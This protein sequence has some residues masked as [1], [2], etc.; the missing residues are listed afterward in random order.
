MKAHWQ[1]IYPSRNET[2]VP[3]SSP[4]LDGSSRRETHKQ[5]ASMDV[6]VKQSERMGKRRV[7]GKCIEKLA[8]TGQL[9][10]KNAQNGTAG[11]LSDSYG[12]TLE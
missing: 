11:Q 12:H 1:L 7:S 2:T 8:A 6:L 10:I 5:D 4:T 3:L 9:S